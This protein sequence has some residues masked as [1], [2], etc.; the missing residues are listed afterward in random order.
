M[1]IDADEFQRR[2][3]IHTLPPGFQRIRHYGFLANCHRRDKLEYCRSLLT[4]GVAELLPQPAE[5]AQM[6]E[7]ITEK[8][9]IHRCPYCGIGLIIRVALLPCY[10]WPAL[11]PTDTS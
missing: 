5:C 1:T 4:T 10:R 3:L 9:D 8:E 6:K 2:F 11:P 7:A